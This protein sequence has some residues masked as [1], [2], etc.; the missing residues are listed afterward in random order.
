MTSDQL[1][2][3]LQGLILDYLVE[4]TEGYLPDEMGGLGEYDLEEEA[5]AIAYKA[6]Q[7]T[8]ALFT[9]ITGRAF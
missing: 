9:S 6:T 2:D 3:K 5:G 1:H 8:L 4:Q 7:A